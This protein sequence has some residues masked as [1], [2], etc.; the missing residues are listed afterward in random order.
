MKIERFFRAILLICFGIFIA[1]AW[2]S[3]SS[4]EFWVDMKGAFCNNHIIE[5]DVL[6]KK[7][8]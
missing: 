6:K 5:T 8:R 3:P 7:I 2:Q 1:W 4:S